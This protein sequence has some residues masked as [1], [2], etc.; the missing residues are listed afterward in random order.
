MRKNKIKWLSI[1]LSLVVLF[2]TGSFLH[3]DVQAKD[4]VS[5]SKY[6]YQ[7]EWETTNTYPVLPE[8]SDWADLSYT[9]QLEACNMPDDLID[10]CSTDELANFVLKYPFLIDVLAFD[11]AE[12]GLEHLK[13]TSNICAKLFSKDNAMD[14]LLEEYDKLAVDYNLLEDSSNVNSKDKLQESGYIKEIFLQT[15]FAEKA[16]TMNIGEKQK[17]KNIIGEKYAAK[18]GK[19]DDYATALLIY[20]QIQKENGEVPS[21]LIP[22]NIKNDL[23]N[24]KTANGNLSGFTS[25]GQ[26]G[27]LSSGATVNIGTYTLYGKTV[28]CY[29]YSSGDYTTTEQNNYNASFDS[30]HPSWSRVYTCTKKYNCHSYAWIS[31]T[32]YNTYWL[33][34]PDIFA[35][36]SSFAYVGKNSNAASGNKI[37]I[38][39]STSSSDGFG[40]YTTAIHSLN[41][42]SS[43]SNSIAIRTDSKLGTL[44]VYSALLIDMMVFYSGYCYVVY[45]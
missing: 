8:N 13:N 21:D 20:E 10:K 27:T 30:A 18:K 9:E 29:Q 17:L 35:G 37:I 22:D 19:C 40:N 5:N 7:K 31:S 42:T 3:Q 32:S 23:I 45:R 14:V 2:S 43:G 41:A 25:S 1:V 34:N 12:Q 44:G 33:N 39:A 4:D 24:T 11:N 6:N 16:N 26:S 28:G 15:Y 36:S 38:Q